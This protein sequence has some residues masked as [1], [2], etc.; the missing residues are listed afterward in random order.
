[1]YARRDGT[2]THEPTDLTIKFIIG[3]IREVTATRLRSG[4]AADLPALA[5][6]LAALGRVLPAT[7]PA[8]T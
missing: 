5:D 4:R 1:M 8:G 3:G 2:E 6:E 7:P